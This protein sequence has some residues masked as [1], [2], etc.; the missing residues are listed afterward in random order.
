[1]KRDYE[2]I[3]LREVATKKKTREFACRNIKSND[4]LGIVKWYSG[5]RR[6]CYFPTCKAV[7]SAGCLKDIT[8]FIK[9]LMELRRQGKST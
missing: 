3:K 5:W 7:Y 1:M 2:Y 8:D 9:Q 4:L 6:Y